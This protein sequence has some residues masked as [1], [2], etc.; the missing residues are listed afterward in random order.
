MQQF[1]TNLVSKN[2]TNSY[3]PIDIKNIP[4][5][6]D[7]EELCVG[8]LRHDVRVG[9]QMELSRGCSGGSRAV[10]GVPGWTEELQEDTRMEG[11]GFSNSEWSAAPDLV[12]GVSHISGEW[13]GLVEGLL[14]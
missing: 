8:E 7:L 10:P 9:M 13:A 1:D 11:T 5:D 2:N 12:A 14:M 3:E 6:G 4:I